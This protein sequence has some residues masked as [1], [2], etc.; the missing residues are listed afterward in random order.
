MT[1]LAEDID[2]MKNEMPEIMA[3]MGV[4]QSRVTDFIPRLHAIRDR[5]IL[6]KPAN[7]EDI[8]MHID[9][10]EAHILKMN[11]GLV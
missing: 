4:L 7:S 5:V 8:L 2:A 1:T 10:A 6:E 9:G 3:I 11:G